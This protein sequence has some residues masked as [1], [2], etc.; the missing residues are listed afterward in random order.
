VGKKK[1]TGQ[2]GA[3]NKYKIFHISL[4]LHLQQF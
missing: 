1:I 2:H 3:Q 4:R